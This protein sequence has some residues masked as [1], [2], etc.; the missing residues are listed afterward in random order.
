MGL[1]LSISTMN[2]KTKTLQIDP[3]GKAAAGLPAQMMIRKPVEKVK[4]NKWINHV[5]NK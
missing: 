4:I 2:N 3:F 1:T 5:N